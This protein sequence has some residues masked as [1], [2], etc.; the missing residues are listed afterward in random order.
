MV[1]YS[2]HCIGLLQTGGGKWQL[3]VTFTPPEKSVNLSHFITLQM[4]Y[5]SHLWA[6]QQVL[7]KPQLVEKTHGFNSYSE[8]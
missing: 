8:I 2:L 5:I 3:S 6:Q 4:D 7:T 1:A